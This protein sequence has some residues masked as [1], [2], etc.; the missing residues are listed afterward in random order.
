MIIII[1]I[2]LNQHAR[3]IGILLTVVCYK[4]Q[5]M[6]SNDKLNFSQMP[7]RGELDNLIMIMDL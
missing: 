2:I 5:R 3:L 4:V 1:T 6:S 7:E